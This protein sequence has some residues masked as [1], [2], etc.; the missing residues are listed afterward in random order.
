MNS[1]K[2]RLGGLWKSRSKNGLEYL[3]GKFAQARLLVFPN[4]RKQTENSPDY[5]VYVA[6]CEKP[7]TG[8]SPSVPEEEIQF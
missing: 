2:I 7:E 4:V 5:S 3:S 1:Q 6:P 8:T